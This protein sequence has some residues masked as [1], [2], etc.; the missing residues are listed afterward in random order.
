M[1]EDKSD[2]A[3]FSDINNVFCKVCWNQEQLKRLH[4][5]AGWCIWRDHA[6]ASNETKQEREEKLIF[7]E[8][9][10]IWGLFYKTVT[11]ETPA[12]TLTDKYQSN[13]SSDFSALRY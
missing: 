10:K 1:D 3:N 2:P 8:D 5:N 4:A 6:L 12:L 7:Q 9:M 11:Y 13:F